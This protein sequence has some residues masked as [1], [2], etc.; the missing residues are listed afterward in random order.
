MTEIAKVKTGW[1]SDRLGTRVEV[2]RWGHF[3][4]PL[5][6]FPTA[7]GDA[8]ECERFLMIRV[9]TPLILAGRLK[10]YCCDSVS[11]RAWLDGDLNGLQRARVQNRF[12]SFIANELVP[13]I[14]TDCGAPDILIGVAGASIGAFNALAAI[15][16]HPELFDRAFCLSGTYDL[17][18]WMGGQHSLDYHVSSPLHFIPG[19]E[20][21]G[22]Q[23][24]LLRQRL[25]ILGSGEGRWEAPWECWA[26]AKV[27]G[28]RGIPNRVD[29]WGTQWDHDWV[30]WR[31]FLPPYLEQWTE[32]WGPALAPAT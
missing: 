30:T 22:A 4:R 27:L 24:K 6:L 16:R 2:V 25:I 3:G 12:D 19:L 29:L 18:R 31:H 13:A 8:E 21:D 15:C 10:V 23:L 20:Q 7:G 14:R 28:A 1:H 17:S 32:G 5:L 26:V 11:G 9:L